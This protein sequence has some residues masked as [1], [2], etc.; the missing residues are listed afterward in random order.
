[1]DYYYYFENQQSEQEKIRKLRNEYRLYGLGIFE[2]FEEY[3]IDNAER[4]EEE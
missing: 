4:N 3:C 2:S 1:M